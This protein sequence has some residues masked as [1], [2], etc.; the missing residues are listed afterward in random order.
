MDYVIVAVSLG[1]VYAL[2]ALGYALIYSCLRL[3]N[4]AHGEFCMIGAF[5]AFG[6]AL[7]PD[8]PSWILLP[9]AVVGGA[10]A[11][12]CT[13]AIAYRPLGGTDRASAILA[14][15]GASICLQQLIAR[16]IGARAQ[17]FAPSGWDYGFVLFGIRITSASILAITSL[18]ILLLLIHL[19]WT[20]SRF[21]MAI[22]AVADDREA[23]ESIG[24]SSARTILWV[25]CAAGGAAGIA[26]VVLALSFSRIDPYMGFAPALKAFV[27]ALVG[28][29]HDPRRAALGGVALGVSETILV[30]VGLSAYR[31][32][33]I[34]TM[35][36]TALLIQ[37]RIQASSRILRAPLAV[38]EGE[39]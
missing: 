2:I 25:F 24:I 10:L 33:I 36:V 31:D 34:L 39:D 14:A 23:A 20:R 29:L 35:L 15:I 27:A 18:I 32:A 26:G 9:S 22:R 37:A 8:I 3:L 5:T 16:T 1:G 12:L 17:A 21:G 28:G 4:F 30:V 38:E 19:M 13:W 7:L 6:V 11:A